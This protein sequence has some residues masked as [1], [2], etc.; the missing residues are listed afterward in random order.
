VKFILIFSLAFI[1]AY[2]VNLTPVT[3]DTIN[4]QMYADTTMA[5]DYAV[6]TTD[7]D[8]DKISY[9]LDWGDGIVTEWSQLLQS[10]YALYSTHLFKNIGTFLCRVR[11][12]DTLNNISE[13][14]KPCTVNVVPSLLKWS[15]NADAGI[16]SS[17]AIGNSN[18]IYMTCEDGK[19]Y[20][21]NPDGTLRWQFQTP[22]E[23]Y[24]A[25]VIGNKALYITNIAGQIIAVDFSGKQLWEFK[26]DA[27]VYS[28]PALGKNGDIYFG[29][30]DGNLY[31]V[32]Q[33]GK[34]LWQ[35]K[36]GDEIAGSPSIGTDG[37]IYIAS[38]AIYAVSA[39]GKEKW[40][41]RPA[42][43]DDASFFA[44]PAIGKDGTIYIGGT[45]GALYVI[46]NQGRLKWRIPT[47][48]EDAIR[49]CAVIDKQGYVYF[50]DENGS[51]YKKATYGEITELFESDYYIFCSPAV[52]SLN[53]IYFVSDDGFFY[54]LRNDGKLLFKWQVA[55]DSKEMMYSSSP[56]IT[57]DGTVY[58]G[59]WEKTLYAFT[60]FAPPAKSSWPLSRF[61]QQNSGRTEK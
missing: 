41:F 25:P 9:Q 54:C 15:Y 44:S 32:S 31:A 2:A 45:D 29:C 28:T 43:E 50:G 53:N 13:W 57:K 7:P 36:T 10:G 52:D 19:L 16:Y 8:K 42:E 38:D 22:S 26:A 37:T 40:V 17:V 39:K 14:S 23:I 1:A 5:V 46:T 3:P 27:P 35:Y 47:P 55:E 18:E 60:G 21:M 11:A 20:S 49:A 12:K 61:N 4:I 30:D 6:Q 48:E 58:V 59:S 33:T 56:L 34:L 51:L 24:S